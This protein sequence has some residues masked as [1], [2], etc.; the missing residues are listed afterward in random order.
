MTNRTDHFI[1][2]KQKL[3]CNHWQ[4]MQP[5]RVPRRT[6]KQRL[7]SLVLKIKCGS[8]EDD[9]P[10]FDTSILFEIIRE[11]STLILLLSL[12]LQNNTH[13]YWSLFGASLMSNCQ[14]I[15]RVGSVI[16]FK[17]EWNNVFAFRD[18]VEWSGTFV[19]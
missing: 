7:S 16:Y 2:R 19:K 6:G 4:C 15:V 12:Q 11:Q 14:M 8:P 9:F 5:N 17:R 3:L 10:H 13:I 1:Y 18:N